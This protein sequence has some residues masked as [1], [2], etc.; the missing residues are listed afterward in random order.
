MFPKNTVVG[1]SKTIFRST[2]GNFDPVSHFLSQLH[3]VLYNFWW[4]NYILIVGCA[5][6]YFVDLN[7]ITNTFYRKYLKIMFL[8]Q[9]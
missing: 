3:E 6:K 7:Q 9:I 5:K 8:A 2:F 4:F 1:Q